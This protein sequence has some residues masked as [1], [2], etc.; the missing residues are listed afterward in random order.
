MTFIDTLKFVLVSVVILSK[1]W[2]FIVGDLIDVTW[3]FNC[4]LCNCSKL[5]R[6][7]VVVVFLFSRTKVHQHHAAGRGLQS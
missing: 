6:S 3:V 5:G 2:R 7:K 4:Q 1:L